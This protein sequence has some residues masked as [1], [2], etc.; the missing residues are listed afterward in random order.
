MRRVLHLLALAAVLWSA[1][2]GMLAAPRPA[3]SPVAPAVRT[4]RAP[5]EGFIATRAGTLDAANP[6][7]VQLM[8]R[9]PHYATDHVSTLKVA[10]QNFFMK[11]GTVETGNGGAAT[12]EAFVEYPTG[13][14]TRIRFGGAEVGHLA[15]VPAAGAHTDG[16]VGVTISDA[17]AVA[18]SPGALFWIR[19]LYTNPAGVFYLT[20]GYRD[21]AAGMTVQLNT[22]TSWDAKTLQGPITSSNGDFAYAPLAIIGPTT[23]S[24]AIVVG[25]SIAAGKGDILRPDRRDG[26]VA[27]SFP[28]D[29]YAFVNVAV[30]GAQAGNFLQG[31]PGRSMIF[32]Y[33]SNVINELGTNDGLSASPSAAAA[34]AVLLRLNQAVVTQPQPVTGKTFRADARRWLLPIGPSSREV[35]FAWSRVEGQTA[36]L[37]PV[38]LHYNNKLLAAGP[39]PPYAG[40]FDINTVLAADRTG[41]WA[42]RKGARS[43]DDVAYDTTSPALTSASAGF[44]AADVGSTII[45]VGAGASGGAVVRTILSVQNATRVTLDRAAY[46]SVSG[47]TAHLGGAT[48]DGLHPGIG[49]YLDV[50]ASGVI[51]FKTLNL[52]FLL[53]FASLRRRRQLRRGA[54]RDVAR[55]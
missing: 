54:I 40:L 9:S 51:D 21:V 36:T 38:E 31:A 39:P 48:S 3:P 42:P 20:R 10:F 41:R 11:T 16:S 13:V 35:G 1:G 53:P 46:T 44:T 12:V 28:A 17:T 25:D 29:T 4:D 5:Y 32:P 26:I 15:A 2:P 14:F 34:A 37:S 45:I 18:I 8:A 27:R 52:Q 47:A 24:T 33:A 19:T 43:L 7:R 50:A 6:S 23:R 22:A 30:G 55:L 49:G